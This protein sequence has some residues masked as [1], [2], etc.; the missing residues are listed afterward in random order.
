M[1]GGYPTCFAPARGAQKNKRAWYPIGLGVA[2]AGSRAIG[3]GRQRQ[4]ERDDRLQYGDQLVE[5][6]RRCADLGGHVG[7]VRQFRARHG[8]RQRRRQPELLDL[9]D[10]RPVLHV[11]GANV[12]FNTG[13]GLI[14]NANAGQSISIDNSLGGAGGI[15]LNGNSTLT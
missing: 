5:P 2:A 4:H 11:T 1:A 9:R 3:L 13:T 8:Q 12:T 6:S 7:G 15:Q 10:Q 14:D